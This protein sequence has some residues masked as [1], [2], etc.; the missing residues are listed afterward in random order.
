[1]D[2]KKCENCNYFI[3]YYTNIRGRYTPMPFGHCVCEKVLANRKKRIFCSHVCE[4]WKS[5]EQFIQN[6]H[7]NIEKILRNMEKDL[8]HIAQ[9]L[10]E[11]KRS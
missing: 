11:E 10:K 4:F 1:M 7:E 3:L 8:N 9:I 5:N 2:E 6:R